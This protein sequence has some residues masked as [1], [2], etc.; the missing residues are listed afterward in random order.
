MFYYHEEFP[1]ES[2]YGTW[3]SLHSGFHKRVK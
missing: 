1:I 2:D 3:T